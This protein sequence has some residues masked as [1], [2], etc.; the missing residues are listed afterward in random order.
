MVTYPPNIVWL[1]FDQV[2]V[3]HI[4]L[5]TE[6]HNAPTIAVELQREL[7]RY[8]QFETYFQPENQSK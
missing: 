4:H 5:T 7:F 6:R 1:Y 2:A 3:K 8:A